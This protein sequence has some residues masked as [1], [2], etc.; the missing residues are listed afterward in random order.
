MCRLRQKGREKTENSSIIINDPS[1]HLSSDIP[2]LFQTPQKFLCLFGEHFCSIQTAWLQFFI[3]RKLMIFISFF[4]KY[5]K[6]F[7][8][9][10]KLKAFF[11]LCFTSN[12]SFRQKNKNYK[13]AIKGEFYNK[14][15]KRYIVKQKLF[16][17]LV[18]VL[19]VGVSWFPTVFP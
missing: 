2:K 16:G 7:F 3:P 6:K 9:V 1:K 5:K 12:K 19:F 13:N 11:L 8:L 18:V 4:I 14:Y 15:Q 17:W 10:F